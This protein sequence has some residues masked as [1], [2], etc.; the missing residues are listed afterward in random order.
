V[1]PDSP[2]TATGADLSTVVPSPNWPLL[3]YPQHLTVPSVSRAQECRPPVDIAV[4]AMTSAVAT[5]GRNSQK[6][7]SAQLMQSR[8]VLRK[9]IK[10]W[11]T[12]IRAT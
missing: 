3:L 8:R 5:P 12:G 6:T 4:G 11:S 9:R 2:V 7:G 10:N 1:T